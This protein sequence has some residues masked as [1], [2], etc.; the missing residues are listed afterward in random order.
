VNINFKAHFEQKFNKRVVGNDH[1]LCKPALEIHQRQ[2]SSN[3][4]GL[5]QSIYQRF[6]SDIG[7]N[8]ET[9]M[10]VLNEVKQEKEISPHVS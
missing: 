8:E 9:K 4:D 1:Q 3:L 10:D 5:Y 2:W 7:D 6:K